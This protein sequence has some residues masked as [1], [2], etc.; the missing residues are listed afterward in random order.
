MAKPLSESSGLNISLGMLIQAVVGISSLIWI[1]S[2]LDS[3]LAFVE[4]EISSMTE[5]VDKLL[6]M[7]DAP[8]TSDYQQFERLKYLEKELDRIRD[9]KRN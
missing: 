3:R 8:I 4:K 5:N 2:Q 9:G 7:Q 6:E 1:Y